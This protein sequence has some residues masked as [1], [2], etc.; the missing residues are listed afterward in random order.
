MPGGWQQTPAVQ[1]KPAR[2]GRRW[3]SYGLT[4]LIALL[5]GFGIGSSGTAETN[6]AAGPRPTVT[7]TKKAVTAAPARTSKQ[8]TGGPA[9]TMPGD[10]QF[11]VGEDIKPGVY[12]TAGPVSSTCYWARLRNASGELSAIIANDNITGPARVA[13]KKGEYFETKLCQEWER[14]G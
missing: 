1:P 5:V 14:V 9:D 11:L 8:E 3:L 7:V 13:L 4:A 12:K 10:G 2:R 6:T